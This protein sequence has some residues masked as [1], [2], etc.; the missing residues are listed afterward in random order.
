MLP[1][2]Q[3]TDV[4][5]NVDS[6]LTSALP[7]SMEVDS[8]TSYQ[9]EFLNAL[10]DDIRADVMRTRNPPPIVSDPV[11]DDSLSATNP[12]FLAALPPELREEV[13]QQ[14]RMQREREQLAARPPAPGSDLASTLAMLPVELRTEI[15]LENGSVEVDMYLLFSYSFL[16]LLGRE[17]AFLDQL[18]PEQ[19]R[20][21]RE[22]IQQAE[23]RAQRSR[24]QAQAPRGP[25]AALER[26]RR[27]VLADYRHLSPAGARAAQLNVQQ[28]LRKRPLRDG[29]LLLEPDSLA[30]L[31]ALL[32]VPKDYSKSVFRQILVNLCHHAKTRMFIAQSLV[33]LLL[34]AG[35]CSFMAVQ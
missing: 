9:S 7:N 18:S 15:Y 23:Q 32:F 2:A 22:L 11:A 21:A 12:E 5:Q 20:E 8:V 1:Q 13:L 10:P 35:A 14:E 31:I 33:Q 4:V 16:R 17:Q 29:V 19:A 30:I 24:I 26:M 3:P 25:M 27:A 6:Q 28:A 34:K